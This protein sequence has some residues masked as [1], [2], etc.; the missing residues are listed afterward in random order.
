M[1]EGDPVSSEKTG[2]ANSLPAN[3]SRNMGPKSHLGLV[4]F[5]IVCVPCLGFISLLYW[6]YLVFATAALLT[7]PPGMIA[8]AMLFLL[9]FKLVSEGPV[10]PSKKTGEY[11]IVVETSPS[12][13]I[14]LFLITL[15]GLLLVVYLLAFRELPQTLGFYSQSGNQIVNLILTIMLIYTPALLTLFSIGK[16]R[17]DSPKLWIAES[18]LSLGKSKEKSRKL[19]WKDMKQLSL[20]KAPG[21]RSVDYHEDNP[22]D[23]TLDILTN[24]G[25]LIN[26]PLANFKPR[27]QR[28]LAKSIRAHL[29]PNRLSEPVRDLVDKWDPPAIEATKIISPPTSF[30]EVWESDFKSQLARTNYVPLAKGQK[31]QE[32]RFEIIDYLRSGG[33]S[34]TYLAREDSDNVVVLKESAFPSGISQ[35]AGKKLSELFAREAKL[36][37]RCRHERIVRVLDFF[38]ENNREYLVL[39]YIDGKPLNTLASESAKAE[40]SQALSW[41]IEMCDFLTHLHNLDPPILHRDFTPDNLLLNKHGHLHLIDFGA[42]NEFIGN[43][44]GTL[45]GKQSYI[46]PEQFQGKAVPQSDIYSLCATLHF[47]LTGKDPL[48]LSPS[49]PKQCGAKI[50]DKL[51]ELIAQG[52]SLDYRERPETA[53]KLK[54]ELERIQA[55]IMISL[56]NQPNS[57]SVDESTSK[58]NIAERQNETRS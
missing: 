10:F 44:T 14:P 3:I 22:Q 9:C 26:I 5:S 37:Q 51:D 15:P 6:T 2:S 42:A 12:W 28:K 40:Q 1:H 21:I 27:E 32:N 47:L 49:H 13:V 57:L 35:E 38:H 34:T 41:A 19:T 29:L 18:G 58:T 24:K 52:T 39:E 25:A 20:E 43:A 30:T 50:S 17:K 8:G 56:D 45:I 11:K 4:I 46:A 23:H 48:P 31:L 7:S 55:S 54:D 16:A 53:A 36:L 33:F